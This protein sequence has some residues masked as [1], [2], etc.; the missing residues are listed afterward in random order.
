MKL[1]LGSIAALVA[2]FLAGAVIGRK[3][4]SYKLN[5]TIDEYRRKRWM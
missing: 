1:I 4:Q 2:L 3:V 5:K